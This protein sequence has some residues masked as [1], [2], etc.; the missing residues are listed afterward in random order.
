M[1][2]RLGRALMGAGAL[3]RLSYGLG[4]LLAPD[5]MCSNRL[6][7]DIRGHVD[8]R[9]DFRGFGGLHTSIALLTLRAARRNRNTRLL[10]ALNLGCELSDLA[11]TLLEWRDRE[12]A[13]PVV[14]G[15][16]VV[17]LVGIAAWTSA[18]RA[19]PATG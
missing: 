10:L 3:T 2:E 6:A 14:L 13:D 18:L 15:S 17:A 9:M 12:H 1:N 19:L 11:A 16:L 4:A 7:P 5:A 8:G